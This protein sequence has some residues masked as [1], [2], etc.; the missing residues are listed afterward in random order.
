MAWVTIYDGNANPTLW[1]YDNDPPDPGGGQS[2]LWSTGVAGIRTNAFGRELYMNCR[3]IG[4]TA[5]SVPSEI[6]KTYLDFQPDGTLTFNILTQ[7]GDTLITES[8]DQ[9]RI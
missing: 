8:G 5:A 9:I 6:S 7:S 4:S 1:E 3:K 2:A